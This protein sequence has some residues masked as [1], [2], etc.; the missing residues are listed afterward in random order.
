M[1]SLVRDVAL[2]VSRT[3]YRVHGNLQRAPSPHAVIPGSDWANSVA[4]LSRK[5]YSPY[6]NVFELRALLCVT[7]FYLAACAHQ[8]VTIPLSNEDVSVV[9]ATLESSSLSN[10]VNLKDHPMVLQTTELPPLHG[11]VRERPTV[12]SAVDP[13]T[14]V[15]V[16]IPRD[17]TDS[18]IA[19]NSQVL[20]VPREAVPDAFRV[21]PVV[22]S[23]PPEIP[24][25]SVSVPGY[26]ADGRHALV[27]VTRAYNAWCCP[28]GY[29][30]YL[31]K[32]GD[33][34]SVVAVCCFWIV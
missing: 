23:A 30:A 8:Q 31:E 19:R 12:Y 10:F 17:A 26:S 16:N 25:I 7:M 18:I 33:R 1:S 32:H 34:W 15:E 27:A 24:I 3:S 9:H 13:T 6:V 4:F 28:A 21:L 22:T 20:V 5:R 29:T 14:A 2:T 11:W